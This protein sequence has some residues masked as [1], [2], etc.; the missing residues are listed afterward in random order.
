VFSANV[1]LLAHDAGLK[2]QLGLARVGCIEI[3]NRVFIG[4]GVIVLPNVTIGDDCIIG[5]GSV[6]TKNIPSGSIAVGNP[7]KVICSM[8]DYK[9]RIMKQYKQSPHYEVMLNVLN[10]TQEEKEKQKGELNNKIGFKHT[11]NHHLFSHLF[12][13]K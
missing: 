6:V 9:V 1:H 5:A 3:G 7:A 4:L 8:E 10:M 11:I 13:D 12:N 2:N